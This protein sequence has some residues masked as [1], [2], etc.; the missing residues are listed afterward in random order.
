MYNGRQRH[1][2]TESVQDRSVKEE[3]VHGHRRNGRGGS[4][5]RH[6]KKQEFPAMKTK[7]LAE[8]EMY[9]EQKKTKQKKQQLLLTTKK[10]KK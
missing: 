6:V 7:H 4:A 8:R 2:R 9:K 1:I 10:E 5:L 3:S